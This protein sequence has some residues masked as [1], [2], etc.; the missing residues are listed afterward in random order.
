MQIVKTNR[1][2]NSAEWSSIHTVY[3]VYVY[4][5]STSTV[6]Y[7]TVSQSVAQLMFTGVVIPGSSDL[8]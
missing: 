3:T 5:Y 2:A 8:Q 1:T 7:C 4:I 6:L